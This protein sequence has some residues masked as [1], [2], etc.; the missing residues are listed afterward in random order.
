MPGQPPAQQMPPPQPPIATMPKEAKRKIVLDAAMK[1]LIGERAENPEAKNEN[2]MRS[3]RIEIE[4]DS[5][6]YLDDQQ[7]KQSRMEF[8]NSQANFLMQMEKVLATAGP[9]AAPLIPVMMEMWKFSAQA[10]K[11]GKNIEGAIDEATEK[12]K[13]VAAKPPAP[14]PP[15]PKVIQAQIGLETAKVEGQTEQQLAPIRAQSETVKAQAGMV[16]AN[17]RMVESENRAREAQFKAMQ[18]QPMRPQ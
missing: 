1:L 16:D 2:P 10:F 4:S 6:V 5:L 12:M 3:F 11:V 18:P 7:N 8:L 17:A 13:A 14:P 15:D 9:M